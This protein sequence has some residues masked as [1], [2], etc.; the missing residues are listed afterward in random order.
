[1]TEQPSS[2]TGESTARSYASRRDVLKLTGAG[3]ASATA[4]GTIGTANAADSGIPTPW[5]DRKDNT[6]VDP[7]GS[8]VILRGVNIPDP[9]RLDHTVPARGKNWD[10][11]ITHATDPE[12]DWYAN[13]IRIPV[14]PGDIA[15]LPPVPIAD[16][17]FH[18]PVAFD[19]SELLDYCET[20]LDPVV[21][22]CRERSVYCI[23]DYHRHWGEGDLP[24]HDD[25]LSEEVQLFW[26]TVAKRYAEDAHVL[27]E[28]YN[29][30]TLP[31]MYIDD[32][33]N[34]KYAG[35]WRRWKKTAQ[36]WVNTIREHAPRNPIIVG[37]PGWSAMP[38]GAQIEEFD[39]DNLMYAYHIYGGHG[40]STDEGF[41]SRET[42]EGTNSVWKDVPLFMTEFGWEPGQD[43]WIS[44]ETD[45]FGRGVSE[46]A[47]ERPI[48]WTAWCFDITWLPSMFSRAFVDGD[49]DDSVGD[50]YSGDI[51]Q[52][53]EDPPCEWNL[54][55]R[56]EGSFEE[57]AGEY[58]RQFLEDRKDDDVPTIDHDDQPPAAPE[59]VTVES[60]GSDSAEISWPAVT[61]T[62]SSGLDHYDITLDGE[63]WPYVRSGSETTATV[64][65]LIAGTTHEIGVRAV[66]TYGN[67]GETAT[68][69]VETQAGDT[70]PVG[71]PRDL[72]LSD[73]T[74]RSVELTWSSAEGDA[75]RYVITVDGEEY[76]RIPAPM[77][78]ILPSYR[79]DDLALDSEHTVDIAT[80][81]RGGDRSEPV[82]AT[83]RP[84]PAHATDRDVLINDYEGSEPLTNNALG[85]WVGGGIVTGVDN[86]IAQVDWD[87]ISYHG[88]T[89][90]LDAS[91]TPLLKV[92]ARGEMGYELS[93]LAL[94]VEGSLD[95]EPVGD[96]TDDRIDTDWSV[97]T[98]DLEAAGAGLDP[99]GQLQFDT[100][101]GTAG[102]FEMDEL[103]LAAPDDP[104]GGI[105]TDATA[106]SLD[107]IDGTV[108]RD[109]DGDGVHEDLSGD[110]TLNFPDVN[111]LFQ[112]T[113][114]PAVQDH[115]SAYDFT[116]DGLVDQQDVLALFE[117]V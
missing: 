71:P 66:D 103:W 52:L 105:D 93:S 34:A 107:P 60:V 69:T 106:P 91:E 87:S 35:V 79:L 11:M 19:E 12:R 24:W 42:E 94:S 73:R 3:L 89:A 2:D 85:G 84:Q 50:P 65:N 54:L 96:I 112:H 16:A 4:L 104:S 70:D 83:V 51:P 49:P 63:A 78:P 81:G 8:E 86:G 7:T 1:M 109:I 31:A 33:Y 18:P 20:Y 88:T 117:M 114:D 68:V 115:V 56:D 98:I 92:K 80:I 99:L 28:L 90:D 48:H 21:E 14:H 25:T 57:Y 46:W 43:R 36:P 44:G 5:L 108:P 100:V 38:E 64:D 39:G 62:G 17:D 41:D 58:I 10:H 13:V 29:E 67:V 27:F 116:G 111:R 75:A 37:S 101:W 45:G 102:A 76:D 15:E 26:S 40:L 95:K 55:G 113:D 59:T 47:D 23:V 53:C 6:M 97:V 72:Q 74:H 61:D 77:S 30:P 110:G 9:K 22:Y 32:W 82:T